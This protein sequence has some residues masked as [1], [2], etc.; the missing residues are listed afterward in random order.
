MPKCKTHKAVEAQFLEDLQALCELHHIQISSE[1]P[2]NIDVAPV[3]NTESG[4]YESYGAE[5]NIGTY[6][7]KPPL[8]PVEFLAIPR[9]SFPPHQRG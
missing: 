1:S 9:D 6:F 7:P 2:I 3:Y 4:L 5:F 8:A